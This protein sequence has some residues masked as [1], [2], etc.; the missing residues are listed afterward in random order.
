MCK[1]VPVAQAVTT[2]VNKTTNHICGRVRAVDYGVAFSVITGSARIAFVVT[3]GIEL[4]VKPPVYL[5][6]RA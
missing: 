1:E 4:A 6:Q 2:E 3:S 5:G